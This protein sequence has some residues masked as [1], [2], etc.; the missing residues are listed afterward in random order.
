ME[1]RHLRHFV[2]VAETRHF[3]RAAE[4]LHIAQPALSQSIRQLEAEL[5]ATLLARTTRQVSLT[6]AGTFFRA[7]AQRILDGLD[8]STRGVRRIAD[9][10]TGLLRIALT[11]T[12][13][14]DQLP[15]LARTVQQHLPGIALEIHADQLTPA[16]VGGLRSAHVDLGLLRPPVVGDDLELRTVLSEHLV[17]A[18]PADHRLVTEPGLAVADLAHDPFVMY[19]DPASAVNGAILRSTRDAGFTPRCEHEAPTTSVLLALVA[20]GLGVALVPASARA[21]PL[22]GVVFRDVS[23]SASIDLALAWVRDHP[24][25]LV[26]ALVETLEQHGFFDQVPSP[27][28]LQ[29]LS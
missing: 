4:L 25:P 5:G 23:G 19:A 29:E 12:A 27:T 26:P 20:A 28:P 14:F 10:R 16:Q 24:S 7:E 22:R 3:G 13:A 17:V 6:P 8:D 18:L 11:G 2:A 15:R 21:L 9:G 1:L